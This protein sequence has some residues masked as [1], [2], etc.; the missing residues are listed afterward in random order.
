MLINTLRTNYKEVHDKIKKAEDKIEQ[1]IANAMF[2]RNETKLEIKLSDFV[3]KKYF[4][5]V[6]KWL[7]NVIKSYDVCLIHIDDTI[8]IYSNQLT[9][10]LCDINENE[11]YKYLL[12]NPLVGDD[13][14]DK[15]Q[16]QIIDV[17]KSIID[18]SNNGEDYIIVDTAIEGGLLTAV[19][20]TFGFK[21]ERISMGKY[22]FY[23]WADEN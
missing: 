19:S 1:I 4:T 11:S 18:A 17:L 22:K 20:E 23:G 16:S 15:Q 3:D 5:A 6:V 21:I 8:K 7:E 14:N 2:C 9:K 13:F 12:T 10:Y